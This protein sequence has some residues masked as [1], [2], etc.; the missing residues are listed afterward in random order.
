MLTCFFP[1]CRC[2]PPH[3]FVT[4]GHPL[5]FL[6]LLT[7]CPFTLH[8]V[9]PL[10]I[11]PRLFLFQF[12]FTL[13]AFHRCT[14]PFGGKLQIRTVYR[15]PSSEKPVLDL[16][17]LRPPS[18]GKQSNSTVFT[19]KSTVFP[20]FPFFSPFTAPPSRSVKLLTT[21]RSLALMSEASRLERRTPLR[22]LRSHQPF[23]LLL[24]FW[25]VDN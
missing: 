23:V 2:F 13:P 3:L 8:P 10:I 16:P 5:P 11:S 6:F 15:V 17:H 25:W 1:P 22:P 4:L 21:A 18:F 9:L 20:A 19:C 7:L 12:F 24:W 14:A